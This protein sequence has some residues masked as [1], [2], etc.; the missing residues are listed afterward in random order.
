MNTSIAELTHGHESLSSVVV[1]RD[2]F[3]LI[4]CR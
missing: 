4:F 2:S 1:Q 3:L